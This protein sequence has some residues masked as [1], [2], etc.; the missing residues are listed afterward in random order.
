V[1]DILEAGR[2]PVTVVGATLVWVA[3]WL[4][5]LVLAGV[6]A[7]VRAAVWTLEI[8]MQAASPEGSSPA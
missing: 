6:G 8:P 1:R 5:G 4:G 7:S 3:I 2:D